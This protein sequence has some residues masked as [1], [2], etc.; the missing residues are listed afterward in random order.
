MAMY[1]GLTPKPHYAWG[2]S[3]SVVGL[4]TG[5]PPKV[6]KDDHQKEGHLKIKTCEQYKDKNGKLRY[7]GTKSL[8]KTEI[9]I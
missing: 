6:K 2:N 7:H 5:P 4:N 3:G 8:K 1:G 9:F